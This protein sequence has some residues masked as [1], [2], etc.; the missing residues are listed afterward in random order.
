MSEARVSS[1]SH[2]SQFSLAAY[3][4]QLK[5]AVGDAVRSR[6]TT[7]F[8]KTVKVFAV[9]SS[10]AVAPIGNTAFSFT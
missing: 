8:S 2:F 5:T 10:V 9:A 1:G 4:F 3:V 6:H 7:A